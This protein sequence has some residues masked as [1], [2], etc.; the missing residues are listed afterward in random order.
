M[1]MKVSA[2]KTR[3][4]GRLSSSSRS[5]RTVPIQHR[6]DVDEFI[7]N[8]NPHIVLRDVTLGTEISAGRNRSQE[9]PFAIGEV[10][11]ADHRRLGFA[12][13]G[14]RVARQTFVCVNTDLISLGG[15]RND[16]R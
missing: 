16:G 2:A 3:G 12:N 9:L 15:V 14:S 11:D 5:S 7:L 4:A 1:R 8:R 10:R 6:V 13:A